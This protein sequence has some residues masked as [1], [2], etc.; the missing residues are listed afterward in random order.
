M[1][2]IL[3]FTIL[4]FASIQSSV[5][6]SNTD[7]INNHQTSY[8][9]ESETGHPDTYVPFVLTISGGVSLG[10]YEAGLNWALIHYLRVKR[11]EYRHTGKIYPQLTAITGASAG[12]INTIVSAINWCIDEER[13]KTLAAT[14]STN[15]VETIFKDTVN[16]NL[17][18]D[19][20]LNVGMQN[21]L[22]ASY[23]IGYMKDDALL[24]RKAFK[25]SIDK[26]TQLLSQ[27]IYRD[28]CHLPIGIT[29]TRVKPSV[30]PIAEVKV[31]N[32]RT[33]IPVLLTASGVVKGSG[34][35]ELQPLMIKDAVFNNVVHLPL[36]PINE[37]QQVLPSQVN[38][39]LEVKAADMLDAVQASSAFPVA[40]SRRALDYCRHVYSQLAMNNNSA[41]HKNSKV[42]NVY[43]FKCPDGYIPD[44]AEFVDGGIF[45]NI[46]LGL[47]KMLAEPEPYDF[48]R[49]LQW[50]NSQRPYNYIYFDPDNRRGLGIE[51]EM[52]A[53][54]QP[55]KEVGN[56]LMT[57]LSFLEGA[58]VT[59]RHYE[60]Y[61]SLRDGS[62]TNQ[63]YTF[64][65]KLAQVLDSE[66]AE[67]TSLFQKIIKNIE[68]LRE[69][70]QGPIGNSVGTIKECR[71]DNQEDCI[72]EITKLRI[73]IIEQMESLAHSIGHK[74][75]A[76]EIS[77]T[78][79][80]K[81]GDR[82]LI[83]PTRFSPITGAMLRNF[84]AFFDKPFREYDYYAGVYD[85][86]IELAKYNCGPS[87]KSFLSHV[88][89]VYEDLGIHNEPKADTIFQYL[90]KREFGEE[91]LKA[92]IDTFNIKA[93]FI[94]DAEMT[95]VSES[96]FTSSTISHTVYQEPDFKE[97]LSSL[98]KSGYVQFVDKNNVLMRRIINADVEHGAQWAQ[99]IVER[100]SDRLIYLEN[101]SSESKDNVR[102]PIGVAA[103][104]A[105]VKVSNQNELYLSRTTAPQHSIAVYFP[106]A[107][108]IDLR[109]GGGTLTWEPGVKLGDG[110]WNAEAKLAPFHHNRYSDKEIFFS[111]VDLFLVRRVSIGIISSLAI[112]PTFTYTWKQWPNSQRF[113]TGTSIYA[114][115]FADKIRFTLGQRTGSYNY[116]DF[117]GD[118]AYMY[119]SITDLPGIYYWL[120]KKP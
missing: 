34:R 48:N 70:Y 51:S 27:P 7:V 91:Q 66:N 17:F 88:K 98:K 60:L 21:L 30:I 112:G 116:P 75:L 110:Q 11:N 42:P 120:L 62:W 74:Q 41:F 76:L 109:N 107:F 93:V 108:D 55:A 4:I 72:G 52:A 38:Q 6:A 53:T 68:T 86:V 39:A 111:Q 54:V 40:F 114:G 113:N 31:Q 14:K 71:T 58:L 102:L 8:F 63:I 36:R 87:C 101:E 94:P 49:L 22:P 57:Q 16:D 105:Q 37:G 117:P 80:D 92:F 47:A 103:L 81:L 15:R 9:T 119:L 45:D 77:S 73:T 32:Q 26:I 59:G 96:I 10:S 79:R 69:A 46:P 89:N 12:S 118:T 23:E 61:N 115:L 67:I 29:L 5:A 43:D 56:G 97:F 33:T 35:V 24:S 64:R 90:F 84:G 65:D 2:Y 44:H 1:K 95:I 20:W 19:V 106:Y 104:M 100:V 25:S 50:I 18:R 83:V 85:A 3:F 13:I 78:R 28:D 99:L 82:R